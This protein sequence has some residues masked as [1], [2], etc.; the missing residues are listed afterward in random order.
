MSTYTATVTREGEAWLAE[1]D[2]EPTA[3]TWATTLTALRREIADAIILAADLPDDVSVT[4]RLTAGDG[5]NDAVARAIELGNRRADLRAAEN[6]LR[7]DTLAT[8]HD[9]LGAGWSV[10]DVAGAVGLTP[11]RIAQIA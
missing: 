4:V 9:L 8:V 11:G 5:V 7:D 1:C 3:H 6:A 2:Q 10:R